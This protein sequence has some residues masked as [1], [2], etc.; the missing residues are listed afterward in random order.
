MAAVV[1]NSLIIALMI[2][3][4]FYQVLQFGAVDIQGFIS[5]PPDPKELS[6]LAKAYQAYV[7]NVTGLGFMISN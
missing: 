3:S 4:C 6:A 5:I 2:L 7:G 1:F